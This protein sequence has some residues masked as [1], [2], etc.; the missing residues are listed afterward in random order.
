VP[1][2]S[3]NPLPVFSAQEALSTRRPWPLT[4]LCVGG[5][6]VLAWGCWQAAGGAAARAFGPGYWVYFCATAGALGVALWGLFCLRRWALWAFPLALLLD[7]A[8]LAAMGELRP[9]VLGI[10]SALVLLVLSQFRAF[11]PPARNTP[12]VRSE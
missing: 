1:N 10:Q 9:A 11:R 4:V 2:L 5:A 7:D 12:V 6:L 3:P 8:V